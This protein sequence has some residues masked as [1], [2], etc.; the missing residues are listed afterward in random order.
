MPPHHYVSNLKNSIYF[1]NF[2]DLVV[3]L[4]N[5]LS[6]CI[7]NAI[8]SNFR[9]MHFDPYEHSTDLIY[10]TLESKF[11]LI[12]ILISLDIKSF[13]DSSKYFQRFHSSCK[14]VKKW[15]MKFEM[16]IQKNFDPVMYLFGVT[17]R[18]VFGCRFIFTII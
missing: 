1:S 2:Y 7:S 6:K 10:I 15:R 13:Y 18:W 14:F 11:F 8:R 17:T 5:V 9:K 4:Y 16:R 12:R 3:W